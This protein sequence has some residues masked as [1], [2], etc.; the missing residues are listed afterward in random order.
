MQ[1]LRKFFIGILY[2]VGCFAVAFAVVLKGNGDLTSAGVFATGASAGVVAIVS[3]NSK[4]H[5]AKNGNGAPK[6]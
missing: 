1:G 4:E 6:P 2:L 5:Q 3:G